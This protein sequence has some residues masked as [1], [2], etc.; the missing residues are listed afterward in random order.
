MLK[1]NLLRIHMTV[2]VSIFS[3][4]SLALFLLQ[5]L[6][7]P[8]PSHSTSYIFRYQISISSNLSC[9]IVFSSSAGS[10]RRLSLRKCRPRTEIGWRR[11]RIRRGRAST[12]MS[13][14]YRFSSCSLIVF[15][16]LLLEFDEIG[17]FF[18]WFVFYR[19]ISWEMSI[20]DGFHGFFEVFAASYLT[21]C[22]GNWPVKAEFS[23][24]SCIPLW[25]RWNSLLVK[26]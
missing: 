4:C 15:R 5:I 14:R 6:A 23:W 9:L 11:L 3:L 25:I 2:T 8:F 12:D 22:L 20:T 7:L 19:M 13:A 21:S 24:I 26:S 16:F 18:G 17:W 10:D 1:K